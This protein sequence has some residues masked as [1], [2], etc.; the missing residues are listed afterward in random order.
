MLARLVQIRHRL[1]AAGDEAEIAQVAKQHQRRVIRRVAG[2]VK[3]EPH[4]VGQVQVADVVLG[5]G[6]RPH[7]PPAKLQRIGLEVVIVEHAPGPADHG[8]GVQVGQIGERKLIGQAAAQFVDR[9]QVVDAKGV[10]RAQRGHDGGDLPAGGQLR[11]NGPLE[12]RQL[13]RIVQPSRYPY[14][15]LLPEPQPTGDVQ[16]R[17]V[18]LLRGDNH[19]VLAH[20]A[21]GRAGQRL[22]EPY[23]HAV[24]QRAGAA[25]R[26]HAAGLRRV[27]A[28]QVGRHRGGPHFGFGK[29]PGAFVAA[30]VRV[31]QQRQQHADHAGQRR[32]GH[33]VELAA[34]MPPDE[35]ALQVADK[36]RNDRFERL[37]LAV[38]HF[39]PGPFVV[40][41]DRCARVS[42]PATSARRPGPARGG[43]K[44][45]RSRRAPG[46]T[47]AGE[48]PCAAFR[49]ARDSAPPVALGCGGH[50]AARRRCRN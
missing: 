32:V 47:P 43:S 27:V 28:H 34:R 8:V 13:D 14:D 2:L 1:A 25:E 36:L 11:A 50:Q 5:R 39:P 20:T 21:G 9:P 16:A 44:T 49:A 45:R 18:A 22:F 6:Q 4:R 24:Q 48:K 26:E 29:P 17:V 38:H 46:R 10:G 33:H 3:I 31:V 42:A 40:G 41:L 19:G 15:V 35:H 23:F 12:R 30:Q 7:G 37:P